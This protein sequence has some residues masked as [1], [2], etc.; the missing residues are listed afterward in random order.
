MPMD[1]IAMCSNTLYMSNMDV[2][3]LAGSQNHD[4]MTSF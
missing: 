4:V 3:E 2:G 1:S